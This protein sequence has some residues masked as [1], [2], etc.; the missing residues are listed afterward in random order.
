MPVTWHG[1]VRIP[2]STIGLCA[3][4]WSMGLDQEYAPTSLT[5]TRQHGSG[6]LPQDCSAV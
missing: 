2:A 1:I 6:S 3:W 4:G 5:G